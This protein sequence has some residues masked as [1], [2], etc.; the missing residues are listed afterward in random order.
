MENSFEHLMFSDTVATAKALLGMELYL[1]DKLIGR[2]VET[3]AYLGAKDS[4]SHSAGGKRSKKNESMYL[5]AGHWYVYQMYGHH[6]LNL[7]TKESGTAEAVLIRALEVE[8]E[9]SVANGPGKL[10]RFAHITQGFDGQPI[11]NCALS[12]KEGVKPVCIDS[13]ARIGVT[14][15]DHWKTEPLCFY[16]RGNRHVS[17]IKKKG[18]LMDNDTWLPSD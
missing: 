8:E 17:R 14:C 13:R 11:D 6:M 7:V 3:E 10:T 5:S 18:L 1:E 2:I 15:T 4:A 9:Q 12:L 16:V